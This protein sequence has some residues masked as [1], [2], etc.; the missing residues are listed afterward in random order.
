MSGS[1]SG[2]AVAGGIRVEPLDGGAIRRVVLAT[3]KANI[4]DAA[5]LAALTEAFE[6]ARADRGLKAILI[7]GEGDHF[8]FGAS[9]PEHLPGKFEEMIPAFHAMFLRLLDTSVVTV[10]AV[11]GQCLG[12]GLELAAF[13]HR[14]I[15][16]PA[17]KLG[18]PEIVLGVLAPVASV[19]L[20]ERMGRPAAEDLLL[21]G[22]ILGVEEAHARGLVDEIAEDPGAAAL[23]WIRKHLLPRSASS[24]RLA[25]RAARVGWADR[26]RASLA[27]AERL[28][29]EELM[30]TGDA[31]EGLQSFL[32]KRDPVWRNS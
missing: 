30:A 23:A 6:E 27:E 10:A 5:K 15:A 24:L 29:L 16:S 18:Q 21:T 14:I 1:G 17:A 12:G 22:R 13:C 4:L 25:V 8:S 26:F 20:P 11:R 32:E 19:I 3:P 31:V 9:V 28:Y 2:A 7:E